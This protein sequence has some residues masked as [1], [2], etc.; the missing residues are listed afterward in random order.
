MWQE[1]KRGTI[2]LSLKRK[3]L[4]EVDACK[5][6]GAIVDKNRRVLGDVLKRVNE[7]AKESGA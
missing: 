4:E 5:Y 7:V 3:I 1:L 2:N 6:M